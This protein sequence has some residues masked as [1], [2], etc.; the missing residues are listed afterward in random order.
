[1]NLK[2]L[3]VKKFGISIPPFLA[4][5]ASN[6]EMRVFFT[7]FGCEFEKFFEESPYPKYQS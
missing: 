3:N 2:N 5:V 7:D 1:M 4:L 6:L